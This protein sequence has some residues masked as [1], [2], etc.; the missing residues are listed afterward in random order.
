VDENRK[1]FVLKRAKYDA[2]KDIIRVLIISRPKTTMG[3]SADRR[4]WC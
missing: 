3:C 4:R 2:E 1:T